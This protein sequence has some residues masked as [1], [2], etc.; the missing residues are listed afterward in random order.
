MILLSAL[1]WHVKDMKIVPLLTSHPMKIR[2]LLG[3]YFSMEPRRAFAAK[4]TNQC[5]LHQFEIMWHWNSPTFMGPSLFFF[6]LMSFYYWWEWLLV[7]F[8]M[9][10]L[11]CY[12]LSI[13]QNRRVERQIIICLCCLHFMHNVVHTW[14]HKP[15]FVNRRFSLLPSHFSFLPNHSFVVESDYHVLHHHRLSLT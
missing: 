11:V 2:L 14:L 1:P 3:F 13:M 15:T 7:T 6:L 4:R 5:L 12:S 8:K 9:I 10:E